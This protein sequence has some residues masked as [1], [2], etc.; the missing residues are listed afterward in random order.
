MSLFQRE[1]SPISLDPLLRNELKKRTFTQVDDATDSYVKNN[2]DESTIVSN[3]SNPFMKILEIK[4]ISTDV[5][6]KNI[7]Y[8]IIILTIIYVAMII[9]NDVVFYHIYVKSLHSAH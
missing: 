5:F 6:Y 3:T 4:N 2:V 1:E 8:I 7:I 9:I